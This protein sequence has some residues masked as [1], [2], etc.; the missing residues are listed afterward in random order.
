MAEPHAREKG[1]EFPIR[2][3][4]EHLPWPLRASGRVAYQP[5]AVFCRT[6]L[7]PWPRVSTPLGWG[8]PF[9]PLTL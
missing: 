7:T 4:T 3:I 9:L 8:V 1:R 2:A 5:I 6:Q